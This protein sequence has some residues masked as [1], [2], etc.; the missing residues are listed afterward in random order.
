[1]NTR[2]IRLLFQFGDN[3]Y[4]NMRYN[5]F[6]DATVGQLH[7]RNRRNREKERRNGMKPSK[8]NFIFQASYKCCNAF[9]KRKTQHAKHHYISMAIDYLGIYGCEKRRF[10]AFEE[11]EEKTHPIESENILMYRWIQCK[12]LEIFVKTQQN[13]GKSR[14][15]WEKNYRKATRETQHIIV[16]KKQWVENMGRKQLG[17][18]LKLFFSSETC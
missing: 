8:T 4:K 12:L 13:P 15:T 7:C 1:M 17:D 5:C 10:V 11:E 16:V 2:K 14:E 6:G 18:S 9:Q 3:L